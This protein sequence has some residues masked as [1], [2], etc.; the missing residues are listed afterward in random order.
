MPSVDN[1]VVRMEFDNA[2]FERR[3]QTTLGSLKNLNTAL[4]MEGAKKGLSDIST[5][6][7]KAGYGISQGLS[8]AQKS[9]T[10]LNSA[11]GKFSVD[12]ISRGIEG[13]SKG[14]VAMSA[15]AITALANI[16]TAA[17][18]AGTG[19][20]KS[21]AL[22]N[23]IAGFQEYETNMNSIQTIL[24]N[25]KSQGS[26]LKDVNS[27]LD[28]LNTYSDKTIYNF[29]QMAKNIGTFTAAGVDL[30]TSTSAIKGIA[31]LAAVSGSNAQ[32]KH[33]QQC[34]SCHKPLPLVQ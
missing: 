30:K 19:I 8:G 13:V 31:N 29:S 33:L 5:V 1:R 4:Q 11:A 20:V 9:I 28:E 10:D 3:L 25:T 14:F 16:T 23:V 34:I 17:I 26:T 7:G 24:A 32:I 2:E 12:G 18:H 22:D 27:A 15:I 21:L 6:A